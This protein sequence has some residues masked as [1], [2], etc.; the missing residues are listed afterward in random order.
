MIDRRPSRLMRPLLASAA[1]AA[2]LALAGCNTDSTPSVGGR[3]LQPL[4]ERL[5]ADI[6]AKNMAAESPILV[7]I[8]KE[9]AELEVWKEDRDRKSTRLNSSH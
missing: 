9:E 1:L 7:R 2:A 6:E 4:S 3:H 8:F 5:M